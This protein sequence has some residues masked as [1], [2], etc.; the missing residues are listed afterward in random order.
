[1]VIFTSNLFLF[2]GS[3]YWKNKKTCFFQIVKMAGLDDMMSNMNIRGRGESRGGRSRGGRVMGGWNDRGRGGLNRGGGGWKR[4]G[5]FGNS[6]DESD[7]RH[8]LNQNANDGD[9]R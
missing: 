3:M 1:M 8:K 6:I 2:K 4:G 9:L 5:G 7:L